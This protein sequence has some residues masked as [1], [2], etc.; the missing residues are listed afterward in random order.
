MGIMMGGFLALVF[1]P[2]VVGQVL[3]ALAGILFGVL[4]LG[5]LVSLF[6]V[7]FLVI[8]PRTLA[9]APIEGS[10]LKLEGVH[11]TALGT[12]PGQ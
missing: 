9:P 5:W 2:M 7:P 4:L 3:P 10:M 1:L 12:L 11:G 6:L 8:K